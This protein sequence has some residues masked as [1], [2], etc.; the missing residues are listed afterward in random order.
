MKIKI[1]FWIYKSKKNS[2]G[3][4]PLYLRLTINGKKVEIATGYHI[5]CAD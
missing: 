3:D 4:V 2:E 5:K 1:L